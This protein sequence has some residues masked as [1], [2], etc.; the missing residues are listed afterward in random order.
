M[1]K[2]LYIENIAIIEKASI[3]FDRGF[4][5]LSG[6]T[7]AGKSIIIDAINGIMGGR[8]SRELIRTGTKKASVSALFDIDDGR[9]SKVLEQMGIDVQDGQLSVQRDILADGKNNCKVNGRPC[10]TQTLKDISKYLITIH[11]QHDG[12]LLLDEETH[13]DYLDSFAGNHRELSEYSEEYEKLL[14]LNRMIKSLSMSIKQR[15]ERL[16]KLS[17]DLTYLS[18]LEPIEGEYENLLQTRSVLLGQ[19]TIDDALNF[20]EHAFENDEGGIISCLHDISQRASKAAKYNTM[21]LQLAEKMTE[22]IDVLESAREVINTVRKSEDDYNIS[23]EDVE[24]RLDLYENGARRFSVSEDRLHEVYENIKKEYVELTGVSEENIDELKGKYSI[25]RKKT[26]EKAH[27]LRESREKAA[28]RLKETVEKELEYLDMKNARL[29][30]EFLPQGDG[31]QIKF[32]KKGI[33]NV[34]FLLAANAGE[35]FK[36]LSKVA[37]GGELSRIML[38]IRNVISKGDL[39]ETMIF[40]EVDTGVSGRAANKV[41]E[42]LWS[43]SR[44]KQVLCVTHLPQ[45]AALAD[46][47]YKVSK[48]VEGNATHTRV[49]LLDSKGK[50]AEIARLTGGR[51]ITDTTL[52]SAG[53]I[54]DL[55]EKYKKQNL[56]G[57]K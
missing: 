32:T 13:L 35:G 56:I 17:Y 37:S 19:Q 34:R 23:Y 45:I 44:E 57:G 14:S 54:I 50:I 16:E 55:A 33:D 42:K 30:V 43:I 49:E 10:T 48:S 47:H 39:V 3:D 25:Q 29:E 51:D 31:K 26:L 6:E 21:V 12:T 8:T 7:G 5:V 46:R 1:L 18:N 20:A 9:I 53:E 11:G 27:A 15:E 24:K 22:A 38:A 52:L 2:S 28:I 36:A 41:G 4:S 40:D